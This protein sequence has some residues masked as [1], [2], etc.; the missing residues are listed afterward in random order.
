[1]RRDH[2]DLRRHVS[3]IPGGNNAL[4]LQGCE[5]GV[6]VDQIAENR[7]GCGLGMSQRQFDRVTDAKAHPEVIGAN[8][9]DGARSKHEVDG[10]TDGVRV[11]YKLLCILKYARLAVNFDRVEVPSPP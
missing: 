6:V 2:R 10:S 4:R 1:M 3:R 11:E 7:Q 5:D 8:D 9:L